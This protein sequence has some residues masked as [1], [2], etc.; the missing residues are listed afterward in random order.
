MG[1]NFNKWGQATLIKK[2][3]RYLQSIFQKGHKTPR[4]ARAENVGS[5]YQ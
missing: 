1:Q 2:T 3:L 4:I 5:M